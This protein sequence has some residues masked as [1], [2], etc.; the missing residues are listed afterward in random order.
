MY[1]DLNTLCILLYAYRLSTIIDFQSPPPPPPPFSQTTHII[2]YED[3]V[4]LEANEALRE[5]R[6]KL[7]QYYLVS[8]N[9][10]TCIRLM[11]NIMNFFLSL[12]P[13]LSLSLPP[14]HREGTKITF[15][16]SF[17]TW[18][19]CCHG[20]GNYCTAMSHMYVQKFPLL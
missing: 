6:E 12:P 17:S 13:S 8:S 2:P 1:I 19:M 15:E 5:W 16:V 9:T 4:A 20:D 7:I 10:N 14:T 11:H 18:R 3:K